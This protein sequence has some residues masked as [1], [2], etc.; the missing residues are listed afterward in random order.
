MTKLERNVDYL[1]LEPLR[2]ALFPYL[3]P[4]LN[5]E[6][7]YTVKHVATRAHTDIRM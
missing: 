6:P 4:Q 5:E 3:L 7:K 1:D 2:P